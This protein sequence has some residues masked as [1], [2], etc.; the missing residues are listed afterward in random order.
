[1]KILKDVLRDPNP[2]GQ[3]SGTDSGSGNDTA[4]ATDTTS[5]ESTSTPEADSGTTTS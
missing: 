3:T 2:D 4:L 1:M 5:S